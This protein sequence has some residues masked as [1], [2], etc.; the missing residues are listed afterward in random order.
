M[1]P[2][3]DVFRGNTAVNY[4]G[5]YIAI[6]GIDSDPVVDPERLAYHMVHEMFHCHRFANGE[7]RYPDDLAML[8]YPDDA[9]NFTR[10]YREDL[11][12]ADAFEHKN[13]EKLREF[14]AIR[15]LR[16]EAFPTA[17]REELK[18]ETIEGMAEY[19]GLRALRRIAPDKFDSVL[20][21]YL[22]VLREDG[23]LL[24]NVRKMCYYSGVVFFLCLEMSEI[25]VRNDFTDSATA[26][27]S[28]PIDIS[29][30]NVNA[31]TSETVERGFLSY[32]KKKEAAVAAH[33]ANSAYTECRALIC[34]YDPMNMLRSGTLIYCS[35]FVFLKCGDEIKRLLSPVVLRVAPGSDRDII[36]YYILSPPSRR[37]LRRTRLICLSNS[38]PSSSSAS[39]S[40]SNVGTVQE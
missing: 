31:G 34:G 6:W 24:F 32:K 26:Y 40:C 1:I 28:G 15:A 36:E 12:L 7:A 27:E 23:G 18:T 22:D 30:V 10:K 4:V 17:V 38:P 37:I 20:D 9:L 13:A 14:S 19:V 5:G 21:G 2:R 11:C 29:G 39:T 25:P 8:N 35:H 3:P 33:A 16:A